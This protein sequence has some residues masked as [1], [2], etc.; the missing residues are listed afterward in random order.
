MAITFFDPEKALACLLVAS[1]QRPCPSC[2]GGD[3]HR[4]ALAL[5]IPKHF[6][7][8]GQLPSSTSIC[9]RCCADSTTIELR[10]VLPT[11]RKLQDSKSFQHP[12]EPLLEPTVPAVRGLKR[13]PRLGSHHRPEKRI[14]A[15]ISAHKCTC[16]YTYK[17]M[18]MYIYTY[19]ER[20]LHIHTYIHT[21]KPPENARGGFRKPRRSSRMLACR[22]SSPCCSPLARL[23]L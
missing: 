10:I 20:Y 23:Q 6:A 1:P 19:R 2:Q 13:L 21:Y 15:I 12:M 5:K 14:V 16:M 7:T 3:L 4:A 11:H 22:S 17:Y 9:S 8:V 18:C